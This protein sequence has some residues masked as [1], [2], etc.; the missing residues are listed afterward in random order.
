MKVNFSVPQLLQTDSYGEANGRILQL[1]LRTRLE[2]K[3]IS[4]NVRS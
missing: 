2:T 1:Y 4:A 3:V